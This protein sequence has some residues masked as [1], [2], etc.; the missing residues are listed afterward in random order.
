MPDTLQDTTSAGADTSPRAHAGTSAGESMIALMRRLWPICR[1]ITGDGV[2]ATLEILREGLPQLTVH[3]VPTGTRCFDWTVPREW[4]IRDA[5]I[6]A[7]DGRR[8]ASFADSNLHVVSYSSS[9]NRVMELHELQQHLHSLP[10]QP[11]AIP[12]VTSYYLET[13]GFCL[14]HSDRM[15]LQEGSY[16]VVI[17]SELKDGSLTY[18]EL[19]LPGVSRDEVLLSTYVCHPS[20][21]NNELSGPCVTAQLAQWLATLDRRY[22]YRILFIPET[23]G[24]ICYISR[25]LEHLRTHTRAGFV[26]TCVGDERMWSYMPSRAGD[27]L[28]DQVAQH[29]LRHVAPGYAAYTFLE[30]GSDERQYCSP[31]VD[32]PVCSVMRSKYATYPEYHT[33]L[34]DMRLVTARGVEQ[35]YEAYRLIIRV[36][37]ADCTPRYRVLCEPKM[38]DR[39]LRPTLSTRGSADSSRAAMNVLAYADGSRSLLQ[40]AEVIGVPAWE[41]RLVVDQLLAYDL[42]ALDD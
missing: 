2:R 18:G 20:M 12:Y 22:T 36:L 17:D 32:L 23:I 15:R 4:N 16:H 29:V 30:R 34:D 31:G 26:I 14:R 24:S 8:V 27:T 7:P 42:L 21:A 5:Y 38:S 25:H 35:S 11:D 37:E 6:I 10:D 19:V 1:S 40:I 3:E 9:V 39:G 13:W 28:S 41:L 33:S